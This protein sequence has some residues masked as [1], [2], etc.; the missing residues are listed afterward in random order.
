M[1][2]SLINGIPLGW[3]L[4]DFLLTDVFHAVAGEEH[5]ARPSTKRAHTQRSPEKRDN[6][7]VAR[8]KAQR[9]RLAK[10]AEAVTPDQ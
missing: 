3:S 7:V 1:T 4:T 10:R 2:W 9:E 8:L 5:P 6:A